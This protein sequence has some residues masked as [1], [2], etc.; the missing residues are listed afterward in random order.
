MNMAC[1]CS[2]F[3]RACVHTHAKTCSMGEVADTVLLGWGRCSSSGEISTSADAMRDHVLLHRSNKQWRNR[4]K[5]CKPTVSVF[6]TCR[7]TD[8][9][10]M[11]THLGL[12]LLSHGGVP[13][14]V[15]VALRVAEELPNLGVLPA[16]EVLDVRLMGPSVDRGETTGGQQYLGN[17]RWDAA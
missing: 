6:S 2:C 5:V 7:V 8:K 14:H 13:A 3:G 10:H 1:F 16:D 17:R 4:K 15:H 11:H 9:Q 12:D